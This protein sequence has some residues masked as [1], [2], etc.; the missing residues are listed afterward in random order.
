MKLEQPPAPAA[1]PKA[2]T[3]L[4]TAIY[5]FEKKCDTYHASQC[6]PVPTNEAQAERE[7]RLKEW[8]E[9]RAFLAQER[10]KINTLASIEA[11]LQKYREELN[12]LTSSERLEKMRKELHHPAS[13]LAKHLVAA[14]EPKPS[15]DHVAH[16]I[17]PGKGRWRQKQLVDIRIQLHMTGVRINDPKNGIWLSD[18]KNSKGHWAT[19]DSPSHKS[20]HGTNYEVW[21]VAQLGRIP[22]G[23]VFEAKLRALKSKMKD[24]TYPVKIEQ[25]K[26]SQWDGRA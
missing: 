5:E 26:D 10:H 3:H 21:L 12:I 11:G 13:K 18:P 2:A 8:N 6:A 25:P 23:R 22:A 7:K 20:I 19:P 1:P 4:E 9:A 16:H 15:I 17:V 24:G 14:G